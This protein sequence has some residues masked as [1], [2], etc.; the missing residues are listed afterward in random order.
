LAPAQ[1]LD[2]EHSAVLGIGA[3]APNVEPVAEAGGSAAV[4]ASVG[5][6]AWRRRLAPQHRDAVKAF[7]QPA[8]SG[9]TRP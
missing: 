3:G 1:N 9:G 6:G 5:Q 7:F 2:L 4:Q 8:Q